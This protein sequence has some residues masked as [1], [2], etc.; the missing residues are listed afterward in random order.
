M[1]ASA[2]L[3]PLSLSRADCQV[4]RQREIKWRKIVGEF[5]HPPLFTLKISF[6]RGGF[7][8]YSG[9]NLLS[10][11]LSFKGVSDRRREYSAVEWCRICVEIGTEVVWFGLFVQRDWHTAPPAAPLNERI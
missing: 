3:I 4:D 10:L 1:Y 2:S 8:F 9:S 11:S 5:S 6:P 7:F